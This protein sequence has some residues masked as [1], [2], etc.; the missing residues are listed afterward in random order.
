MMGVLFTLKSIVSKRD[1]TPCGAFRK[2]ADSYL[3]YTSTCDG[4]DNKATYYEGGAIY[5][6][7]PGTVSS[8]NFTGNTAVLNGGAIQVRKG[9]V[10]NCNFVNNAACYGGAIYLNDGCVENCNFVN[11]SA[12]KRGGAIE[13]R[14]AVINTNCN[15]INNT[16][17]DYGGAGYFWDMDECSVE[18]CNFINNKATGDNSGGGAV[19]F[20]R[21]GT[22]TNCAFVNN[23]ANNG[24]AICLKSGGSLDNNW[25]GSNNPD[26]VNLINEGIVPSSYV[27]LN[28]S[29]DS[30]SIDQ[31]FKVKLNYTF[32]RNGTSDV[33]SLPSRYISLSTTGGQ[34]DDTS[35][36]MINGK[37]S[38]EFSSDTG[39]DY[40]ITAIVDN[41]D[42]KINV[43]VKSN[44][45]PDVNITRF[46]V[47]FNDLTGDYL[48]NPPYVVQVIGDDGNPVGEGETVR[49]VFDGFYYDL[50][51]NATGHV[52]RT[53]G[54]AP[55]MYTVKT[56][57]KG[58]NTIATVFVVNQILKVTSGTLKKT[59]KSY[60]LKATLKSSNGKALA[61]KKV[62]LTFKGKTYKVFTN[63]K[64]VA[65]KRITVSVIKTLKSGKTYILQARYVND[66]A[67]GKIKVV[68]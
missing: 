45:D 24:S 36:Y 4:Y 47:G 40:E 38:T 8:C 64:G 51:T 56:Y 53:I 52:V 12:T 67:K 5:L 19:Y 9:S 22:A 59:A 1:K 16:A 13:G 57:Y 48:E 10:E 17:N 61:N 58:Y 33:L 23:T 39:G 6:V 37:F 42:V 30:Q 44:F 15:F 20:D 3:V 41:Q 27:V 26:F 34:L 66:I 2:Y 29:A 21:F 18:N 49:V 28:V 11:N 25:W 46:I 54:L 68:K 65:S 43:M 7:G 63:S 60:T 50:K 31:E 32:L 55:G 35:G 62:K 14:S